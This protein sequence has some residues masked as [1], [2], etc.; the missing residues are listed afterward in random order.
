MNGVQLVVEPSTPPMS[1]ETFCRVSP[2]FS[3]A[4]DGFVSEGPRFEQSGPRAN[5]NHHEEVD[6]L[7]TRATCAQTLMAIRQGLFHTFRDTAGPR[8]IAHVNDCDEDVCTSWFLLKHGHLS[9]QTMNPALNR[10]VFMEDMLD[11]TAGAYP[12]PDELPMLQKLAWVF[13]PYRRARLNGDVDRKSDDVYRGVITDVEHRI[14]RYITDGGET[15]DLDTRYRVI[16]GGETWSMIREIGAQART[17]MFSDG[18]H[19]F[20]AV[21]ERQSGVWTYT[22]GRMSPFV[23]F[24]VPRLLVHLNEAEQTTNGVDR[25]GGGDTIGGSPRV[26]GSRLNPDMVQQIINEAVQAAPQ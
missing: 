7:A 16:G 1:F 24:D 9:K 10:L 22:I 2:P 11:A 15:R 20:V 23:P 13:E 8:I 12:F 4:L 3:L 17:G 26:A 18:I 25:W 19:A 14:L 6:R 21:R 5:F